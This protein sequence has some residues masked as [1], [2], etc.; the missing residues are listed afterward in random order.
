MITNVPNCVNDTCVELAVESGKVSF[1]QV[2][3]SEPWEIDELKDV[4]EEHVVVRT[5]TKYYLQAENDRNTRHGLLYMEM[6]KHAF[7]IDDTVMVGHHF[8]FAPTS[9]LQ[10]GD[11]SG[12][13]EIPSADTVLFDHDIQTRIFGKYAVQVMQL[14]A[15][16]PVETRDDLARMLFEHRD[17]V[18]DYLHNPL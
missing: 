17:S 5:S 11:L 15:T 4:K 8:V 9:R 13:N 7:G 10:A 18:W 12:L 6:I 3:A 16:H 1:S 14:L 2:K